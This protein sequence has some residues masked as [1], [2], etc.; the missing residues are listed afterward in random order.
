M[1]PFPASRYGRYAVHRT[2]VE[3]LPFRHQWTDRPQDPIARVKH[4]EELVDFKTESLF[5]ML[6]SR[7]KTKVEAH[8]GGT[9][10]SAV[11]SIPANFN[12]EQRNGVIDTAEIAVISVLE[13]FAGPYGLLIAA[14]MEIARPNTE[15]T[16]LGLDRPTPTLS[17]QPAALQPSV[18][19]EFIDAQSVA[20]IQ[21]K[22][23]QLE[24]G[25][26]KL[27]YFFKLDVLSR[28]DHQHC[29]SLPVGDYNFSQYYDQC[30]NATDKLSLLRGF[31]GCLVS[32]VQYS[33]DS[34]VRHRDIKPQNIIVKNDQ[35][36]LADFGVTH[37]W[38]NLT[39]ATTT[40]DS[41]KTVIYAA[42]EAVRVERR[43]TAVAMCS[44]GCVC[45]DMVTVIQGK[46][47][48]DMQ[49]YF[50]EQSD[51]SSFHK[52]AESISV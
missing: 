36:Y 14:N 30:H 37:G 46:T 12:T 31:F 11:I 6:L 22:V 20:F 33:H 29:V 7:P 48:Q 4:K 39:R 41:G 45:L 1:E 3:A 19:S 43:N 28:L 16:L 21:S 42:P 32:A 10:T 18:Q 23:F 52:N 24:K 5:A 38:E 35:V 25:K 15:Y 13:L 17:T 50:H 26:Q 51:S 8:L 9:V 44:L 40:A 34:K 27:V 2:H 49:N 47:F